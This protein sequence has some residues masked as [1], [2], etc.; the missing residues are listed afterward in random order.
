MME[1]HKHEV[2]RLNTPTWAKYCGAGGGLCAGGG[3]GG[4]VVIFSV[5]GGFEA[6]P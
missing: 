6:R 1:T 3:G 2:E 5:M 4:R